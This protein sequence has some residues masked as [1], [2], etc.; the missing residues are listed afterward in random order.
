MSSRALDAITRKALAKDPAQRYQH[1]DDMI[2]DLTT[3]Q[4]DMTR[5]GSARILATAARTASSMPRWV[6]IGGLVVALRTLQNLQRLR[7]ALAVSVARLTV[8]GLQ[9]HRPMKSRSSKAGG[10]AAPDLTRVER[11]IIRLRGQNV[12]LDGDLAA[13][14]E[15]DTR[16]LNQAVRRN[17]ARFPDDFMFQLSPVEARSLRSQSVILDIGRGT[18]RKYAPYAFTEQGVAMLSSVLRSP[19]AIRVNIEIMRAFVQL[20]RVLDSNADLAR[21]LQDLEEKYDGQFRVVFDTIRALMNPPTA[22]R[23]PIGFRRPPTD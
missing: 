18:H 7:L 16:A 15:V 9:C 14:Y 17:S 12:M 2:A 11:A 22:P 21:K 13:L 20:R 1:A 3:A 8:P 4:T 6:W 23:R 5:T 19:R 10:A